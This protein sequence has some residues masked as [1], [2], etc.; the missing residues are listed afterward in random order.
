[1]LI[2]PQKSNSS[3]QN[4]SLLSLEVFCIFMKH[5]NDIIR[6]AEIAVENHDLYFCFFC[7]LFVSQNYFLVAFLIFIAI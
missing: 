4:D 1:M 7:K 6:N 3:F 2:R 5:R